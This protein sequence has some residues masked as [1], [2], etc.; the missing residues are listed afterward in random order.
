MKMKLYSSV[1]VV[2][3]PFTSPATI[4]AKKAMITVSFTILMRM[5]IMTSLPMRMNSTLTS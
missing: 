1:S 4:S 3:T 2:L 5:R